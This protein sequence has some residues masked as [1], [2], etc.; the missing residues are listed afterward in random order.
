MILKHIFIWY[1][2]P[3]MKAKQILK[4]I[5]MQILYYAYCQTSEICSFALSV[6]ITDNIIFSRESFAVQAL[7]ISM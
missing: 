4:I 2:K 7:Q 6:I 1:H 5:S 3:C